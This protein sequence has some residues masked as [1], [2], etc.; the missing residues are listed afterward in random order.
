[1]AS[2]FGVSLFY[3]R[4]ETNDR[5]QMEDW[6]DGAFLDRPAPVAAPAAPK[7]AAKNAAKAAVEE[8]SVFDAFLNSKKFQESLRTA[9]LET[10]RSPEGQELLVKAVRK[11]LGGRK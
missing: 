10:L 2:Y 11:E 7:R 4:G 3:L 9:I 8:S 1:M 5:T 6:M